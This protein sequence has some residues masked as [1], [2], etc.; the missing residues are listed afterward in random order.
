MRSPGV[1]VIFG[2]LLSSSSAQWVENGVPINGP[3]EFLW[4]TGMTTDGSGGAIVAWY[5][6]RGVDWDIYAQRVDSSG[7]VLW[8]PNGVPVCTAPL[9][10]YWPEITADARGGAIVVWEHIPDGV[11][12]YAQ[13]VDGEGTV[14]WEENGIPVV[15]A[16]AYQLYERIISDGAGGA[17]IVWEDER[18]VDCT[19]IYAQRIDSSGMQRWIPDG[20]VVCNAPDCQFD[21]E[22]TTDGEEGAIITWYD[23]YKVDVCV[24]RVDR[25][26]NTLWEENG[27][28]MQ[29]LGTN[30]KYPKIT[31]DGA[32]GAI[33]TWQSQDTSGILGVYAQ[34]VDQDGVP[35]WAERGILVF[36]E[37]PDEY[38]KIAGDGSGGAVVLS[39]M[40]G[41]KVQRVDRGGQLKWGDSVR[42]GGGTGE[43]MITDG[44]NGVVVAWFYEVAG[45]YNIY[46]NRVDSTGTIS[47]DST[48]V[49]VCTAPYDQR[50]PV[51]VSDGEGGVIIA[52]NDSRHWDMGLAIYAQRVYSDGSVGGVG[53]EEYSNGKPLPTSIFLRNYPNPFSSA[54]TIEYSVSR[55][56]RI[57]LR[58]H[59]MAGRQVKKLAD[60]LG[61]PG[62]YSILWDGR[63]DSG[64]KVPSGTYFLRLAIWPAREAHAGQ[65]GHYSATRKV[66]VVR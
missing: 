47:W 11:D 10:Q 22:L 33:V 14:L 45:N 48:G 54:T 62:T 13:R 24:Q 39:S 31:S 52:W 26:G 64:R 61:E 7:V 38:P 59:D 3:S 21:P 65:T 58:I 18:P 53:V 30:W 40:R 63:H 37:D 32:G 16:P 20:V 42:I 29:A 27:V 43:I 1:I 2:L 44:L 19:D 56:T 9:N 23:F 34:R 66:C 17:I 50:Y 25:S 12:I 28:C 60:G 46:A 35:Q 51:L 6:Q 36:P 55:S 41:L 4:M 15:T 5:E 57:S 49:P 8:E